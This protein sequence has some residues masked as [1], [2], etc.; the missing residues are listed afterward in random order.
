[1]TVVAKY[2]KN[3]NPHGPPEDG[4]FIRSVRLIDKEN[5]DWDW[6]P[7]NIPAVKALPEISL[8]QPITIFVGENGTGKSTIIEAL[9]GMVGLNPEGGSKDYRF[10]TAST[11]SKLWDHL[12]ANRNPL[13]REG[14]SYFL[15]AETMYNVFTQR[16]R[17][18]DNMMLAGGMSEE[19]LAAYRQRNPHGDSAIHQM[20]HGESFFAQL[21]EFRQNGLYI[22]DEPEAALSPNRQLATVKLLHDLANR[23]GCQIFMATHSP[24][25]LSIPGAK[26]LQLSEDGIE[27]IEYED[28]E[29][30]RT[31]WAF[32]KNPK[33]FLDRLFADD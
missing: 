8:Q 16:E 10:S 28:T 2:Q 6:Y 23:N 5:I 12:G 9:A 31:Y 25:L 1:M 30:F 24:I 33:A 4:G 29:L 27:E 26:I 3:P 13:G 14:F 7:F 17:Y 19:D 21:S 20:S 11:Q 15:R 32:I 22:L 18:A